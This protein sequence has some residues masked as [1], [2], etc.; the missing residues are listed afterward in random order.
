LVQEVP[1]KETTPFYPRSPYGVAKLYGYW[2]TVNYREA[3]GMFACNGILFN[4]ESPI[5]GE[6]FV[7]R[8]ITRGVA[9]IEVGLD[10]RLYLGNLEA[11]RDWGHARDY[12]EGMHKILQADVPEDYVL[13]TG[14]TRSVREF[15]ELAFAEVGRTIEWRGKGVEE[16]GVDK[17][18][19]K[20]V[21]QIDPTYFRPTEVDL[22]IGDASKARAKLGWAP[23]TPFG[24]L[25]KEM[26]ESDLAEARQDAANGKHAV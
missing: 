26:V 6:T 21:V 17:V 14:E 5:R 7:T 1:Q 18:S 2:I 3:Y 9:R 24:Q 22:L 8:K 19:A 13:A 4:H 15:V 11:K 23:K 12:V 20:T 10:D 25:V 16:I